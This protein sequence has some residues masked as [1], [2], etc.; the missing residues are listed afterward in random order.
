MNQKLKEF[1]E[2]N[3]NVR[4]VAWREDLQDYVSLDE[5]MFNFKGRTAEI[6]PLSEDRDHPVELY[7]QRQL[8]TRESMLL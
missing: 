2:K 7:Y 1:E 3:P 4:C 8:I 5:K 6:P